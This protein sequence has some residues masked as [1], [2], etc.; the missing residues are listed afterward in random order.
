M[1]FGFLRLVGSF[2]C[3]FALD[4]LGRKMPLLLGL[5][6]SGGLC[7]GLASRFAGT[8][9]LRFGDMRM[10]LWLLLILQ[11]FAGIGF[12]P[13]SAYLSEAFPRRFKRQ[14]IALAYVLEMLVQ[15]LVLQF[16][17][18]AISV[19]SN[20]IEMFFF[21]LGSLLLAGFL[22]SVWFMPETKDTTLLQ[23]QFRFQEFVIP[24]A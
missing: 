16:D 18:N 10:A 11:L 4:S 22:G 9:L 5:V 19:G 2:S 17:L 20:L 24:P 7:F 23:A 13:S 6:I 3:A 8:Q 1:L 15:V 14:C 21:G 12:A